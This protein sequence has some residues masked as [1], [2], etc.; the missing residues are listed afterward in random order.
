MK[1]ICFW[2][3]RL[4]HAFPPLWHA[5]RLPLPCANAMVIAMYAG[6]ET[7][8]SMR[9]SNPHGIA[10]VLLHLGMNGRGA[11]AVRQFVHG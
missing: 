3:A 10:A 7:V 9:G 6:N 4:R 1:V 5:G 8:L 2:H 11:I